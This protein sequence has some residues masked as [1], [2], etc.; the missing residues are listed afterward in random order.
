LSTWGRPPFSSSSSFFRGNEA[1]TKES[2]IRV[3]EEGR[4]GQQRE[5]ASSVDEKIFRFEAPS[6]GIYRLEPSATCEFLYGR[7]PAAVEHY[8]V[9]DKFGKTT[10]LVRQRWIL[11]LVHTSACCFYK[12]VSQ[13]KAFCSEWHRN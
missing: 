11:H 4:R 9:S 12:L 8:S 13:G 10:V 5:G 1:N 3:L 6:A 7:I 2:D